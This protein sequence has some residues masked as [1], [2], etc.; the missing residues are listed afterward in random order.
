METL[1]IKFL[2]FWGGFNY[3]DNFIT[4]ILKKK[5]ILEFSDQP[6]YIFCSVFGSRNDSDLLWESDD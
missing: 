3:T 4:D 2:D 6:D 5:Y 1:K